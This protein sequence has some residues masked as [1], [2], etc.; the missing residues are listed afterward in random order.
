[1]I[2][3]FVDK[4]NE[5][6]IDISL[7]EKYKILLQ[8]FDKQVIDFYMYDM[9]NYIY[10]KDDSKKLQIKR[11]G[12]TIFKLE[13]VKRYKTC[14]I[15]KNTHDICDA[16][17]IVP[18][19]ELD[20]NKKYNVDNG[21]LLRTDLHNL[22]DKKILEINPNTLIVSFN[23]KWLLDNKNYEQYNN[24]KINIHPNSIKYLIELYKT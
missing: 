2:F 10:I 12:Q 9:Y 6:L 5:T 18:Y 23:E 16:A 15:S 3:E 21:I 13:L 11:N 4:I 7:D 20:D 22:F 17:H 8:S 24:I 1:M 19:C 14:I